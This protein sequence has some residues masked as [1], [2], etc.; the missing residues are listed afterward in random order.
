M[1]RYERALLLGMAEEI[2][3]QLR[4]RLTEI[5]NLH[6]RESALGIATFQDR[7][8]HIEALLDCVKK[9]REPGV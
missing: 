6:P 1:T 5:E 3:L 7:L 8:R 9:D 2:V 4:N